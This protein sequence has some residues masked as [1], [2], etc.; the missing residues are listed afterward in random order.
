MEDLYVLKRD[1]LSIEFLREISYNSTLGFSLKKSLRKVNI[2]EL[3]NDLKNAIQW[4]NKILFRQINL[5]YRVKSSS[6]IKKKYYRY[7]EVGK[8][9][10]KVF[11]D[12]LGFRSVVSSYKELDGLRNIKEIKFVDMSD[13]KAYDDGYRGI[14]IYFQIDHY[15][16][17][18]EIQY[19][20]HYDRA[21]NDWLHFYLYKNKNISN[22]IG[23]IMREEYEKG[24]IRNE[25]E[26][27]E[28]LEN[29]LYNSERL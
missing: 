1:G 25:E 16:Y 28:V 3:C 26:F 24:N 15:H 10:E 18:I 4:Y 19:N 17:P 11:N 12:T 2:E 14:H 27:K 6:S 5:D 20:T 8:P 21:L 29:V 13:G 23:C 22:K 9:I 7:L